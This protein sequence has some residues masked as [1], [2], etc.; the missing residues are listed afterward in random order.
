M[1][2]PKSLVSRGSGDEQ[3]GGGRDDEGRNLADQAVT[4]GEDGIVL[5]GLGHGH[6]FLQDADNKTGADI[7]E[8]DDD[9][10]NGITLDEFGGTV[11]GPVEIGLGADLFPSFSGLGLH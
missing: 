4:D 7:D 3:T 2:E 11:H 1:S 8:G 5:G 9:T 10:G 6:A